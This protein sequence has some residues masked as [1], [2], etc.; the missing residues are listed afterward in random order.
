M[1]IFGIFTLGKNLKEV[2]SKE[3]IISFFE[4]I[5]SKIV[6]YV[7][8]KDLLGPEKK[9]KVDE[10]CISWMKEHFKGKN[11]IIDWIVDHILAEILPAVTQIIYDCLKRYVLGLTKD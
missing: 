4:F 9:A 1:N 5:Q 8:A 3:N 6:E 10:Q 2:F 7:E 11:S